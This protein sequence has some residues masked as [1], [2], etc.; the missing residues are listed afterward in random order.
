M[1]EDINQH[2]MAPSLELLTLSWGMTLV[3]GMFQGLIISYT[4]SKTPAQQTVMD[5]ITVMILVLLLCACMTISTILTIMALSPGS[6]DLAALTMTWLL[7]LTQWFCW[8]P[9]KY[10]DGRLV[11]FYTQLSGRTTHL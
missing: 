6:G 8:I 3:L 10:G 4:K 7:V 11:I 1:S 5:F 9:Q 2:I